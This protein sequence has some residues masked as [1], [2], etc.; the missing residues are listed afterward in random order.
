MADK[1]IIV[2]REDLT[3]LSSHIREKSG[4]EAANL[5]WPTGFINEVD[6]ISTGVDIS[7]V[8]ASAADILY[9]KKTFDIN[10]D[11]VTGTIQ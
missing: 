8:T 1:K 6:N 11:L 10:G 7:G 4:S 2:E 5:T 9:D 3:S